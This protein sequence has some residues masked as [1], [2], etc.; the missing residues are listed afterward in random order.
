MNF[1]I[2]GDFK[3]PDYILIIG[4]ATAHQKNLFQSVCGIKFISRK[5]LKP[6][7]KSR[8]LNIN[9]NTTHF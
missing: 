8:K 2:T 7:N 9:E 6:L 5:K 4:Q 1:S 3:P